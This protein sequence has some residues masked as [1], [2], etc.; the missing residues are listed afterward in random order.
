MILLAWSIAGL[1]GF[2]TLMLLT[3]WSRERRLHLAEAQR[4]QALQK[5]LECRLEENVR[6]SHA[7]LDGLK[8]LQECQGPHQSSLSEAIADVARILLSADQVVVFAADPDTLEL[9]PLAA[10][11]VPP[12]LLTTLRVHPGEGTLGKL[13]LGH[14][15]QNG[16]CATLEHGFLKGP[17]LTHPLRHRNRLSGLLV[18]AQ[19]RTGGFNSDSFRLAELV[20]GELNLI[21]ETQR[22]S[23]DLQRFHDDVVR[24]LA[25]TVDAKDHYTH[26]HSDRT[27]ALVRAVTEDL[28]LPETLVRQIEYGAFLHDVGKVGISE[29]I[30]TKT[31]SLTPDE[32]DVMKTHPQIGYRILNPVPFLRAASA[33]VLYHQEWYNGEGYPEGLA[34][35]EIPLGARLVAIIDAW[36]AMTSDRTYR[37]AMA[38]NAAI[39]ELRRQAGTQ[40]DPHLVDVFLR[41][42]ERL[43][44]SGV[45]TTLS[46]CHAPASSAGRHG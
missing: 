44:K 39:A 15:I 43:E 36:D 26:D 19:P 38:R 6:Q 31:G 8:K 37:P 45:P 11:G 5:G 33:I 35:N 4:T 10:R 23:E 2:F 42:L 22:M 29:S 30:L 28:R 17:F 24:C 3:F 21:H 7:L 34:G 12:D 41:T 1:G 9:R 14:R 32:Y 25:R 40:F 46:E 16:D 20:V 13:A 18:I 27:R